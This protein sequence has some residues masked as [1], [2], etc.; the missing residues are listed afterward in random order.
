MRQT[1]ISKGHAWEGMGCDCHNLPGQQRHLLCG[2]H[3]ALYLNGAVTNISVCLS[4]VSGSSKL[5]EPEEGA[6]GTSA[7]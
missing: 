5:V 1:P 6:V 7:L 2:A 4:S 3:V